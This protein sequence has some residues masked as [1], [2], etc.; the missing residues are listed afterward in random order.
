MG[1]LVAPLSHCGDAST[2]ENLRTSSRRRARGHGRQLR[3]ETH[4]G[5]G[6]KTSL[7]LIGVRWRDKVQYS[8]QRG[9]KAGRTGPGQ[10]ARAHPVGELSTGSNLR[11]RVANQASDGGM[12]GRNTKKRNKRAPGFV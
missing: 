6:R 2:R 3:K 1:G 11:S 5:Y 8:S 4:P 9:E 7:I 12:K 10:Q